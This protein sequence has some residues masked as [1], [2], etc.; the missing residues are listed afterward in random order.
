MVVLVFL[1]GV[2]AEIAPEDGGH[3]EFVRVREG[4]A[5]F[6]D[7]AVAL[8]GAEVDG[9]ADSGRAH[10]IGF[11]HGAEENLVDLVG[12]GEQFVVIDLDDEGNFVGVLAGDG[13]EDAERGGDRVAFAFDGEL[14][15][16]FT[17]EIVGILG[18]ARAG[19]VLD[20][21]IDGEDRE[22][23]GVA[24]GGRGRTCAEDW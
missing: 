7:L 21:L 19:G 12:E 2:V 24:R 5:D 14:D 11:L 13:A 17:V 10:V 8:L 9:G 6:D 16:I 15:D 20:A 23:A 1:E 18:E 22:V 3:A 4:L